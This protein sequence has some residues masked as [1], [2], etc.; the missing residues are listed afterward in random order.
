MSQHLPW[1]ALVLIACGAR[2]DLQQGAPGVDDG[3]DGQPA[4]SGWDEPVAQAPWG[5]PLADDDDDQDQDS[6]EP[7]FDPWALN[8]VLEGDLGTAQDPYQSDFQGAAAVGGSVWLAHFSLNDVCGEPVPFALFSEGSVSVTGAI[9]N[10][11]VEAAGDITIAG[12]SV[13][14]SVVGGADLLEGSGHIAGDLTLGGAKLAGD[15]VSVS[16]N[17]TEHC[18]TPS[19]LDLEALQDWFAEASASVDDLVPTCSASE[20]Y[21]ELTIV[22]QGGVNVVELDASALEQAWGVTIQ[23]PADAELYLNVHAESLALDGMVWTYEG[24]V[25]AENTLLNLPSTHQLDISQGDH[26]VNILA[27]SAEVS[28][29]SG[30]VSGNLV[31]ASMTGGGQVNC[32]RFQGSL[33]R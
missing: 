17:T 32:G 26:H 10:G 25:I 2:P 11:G 28:F 20:R 23:G 14:G 7:P 31:A 1:L 24:G 22:I 15:S 30:L 9:N 19:V 13:D 3:V 12:A 16:G 8:V 18:A 33:G 4:D 5:A 6:W 27:P 29:P 21:G